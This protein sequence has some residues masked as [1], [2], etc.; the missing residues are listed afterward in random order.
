MFSILAGG[1]MGPYSRSPV[2]STDIEAGMPPEAL[3]FCSELNESICSRGVRGFS[4]VP[5]RLR[6]AWSVSLPRAG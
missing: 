3:C 6:S 5:K 2:Q 1:H 4:T